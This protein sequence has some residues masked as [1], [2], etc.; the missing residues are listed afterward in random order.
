[1]WQSQEELGSILKNMLTAKF[2]GYLKY[3]PVLAL[4]CGSTLLLAQTTESEEIEAGQETAGPV[5]LENSGDQD[6]APP[7]NDGLGNLVFDE[8]TQSY[9]LI[10]DTEGDDYEEPP[11]DR[12]A[13]AEELKRLFELFRQA[14]ANKDYLEAD[15]L[16]KRVVELSISLN[17]LDSHDTA[18]AITNLG[19]AQHNNKDY[20]SALRNFMA[21]IDIIE[22][23]DDN[24]SPALI[25]PLQGL[26]ASQAIT[27]RPDLAKLSYERAVHVS[28]VNDGPHNTGQVDI[29]E[30][31]AEL[32]ISQGSWEDATSIQEHIYAIQ[33]RKIDPKS[34]EILPALEQRANWQ[35]RLQRYHRERIT[36]RQI[37]SIIENHHGKDSLE[38]ISPLTNLGKSYLFVSPAEFDYQPEVSA[39]SGESYLRR[40]RIIAEEHP[41]STWEIVEDAL[42]SLG[43]YYILA[44]R[45]NRA[46]TVYEDTWAFLSEGDDPALVQ[47][48]R[49]HLEKTKVLQRAFPPKYYNSERNE[50]DQKPD[51]FETGLM[52]FT[53]T[54]SPTGR[55]TNLQLIES[56][57]R[58]L[59]EFSTTIGRSLRRMI[60]RPRMEDARLVESPDT[61]Y[62]HEFYYR[63]A[64]VPKPPPEPLPGENPAEDQQDR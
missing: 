43:D 4:L 32:H 22:R 45:P 36:W 19:I 15:T 2:S 26:A 13:E 24:L 6:Q 56:Q 7:P 25:N 9:R 60:Y 18:K 1:V 34:L 52:S 40:A 35:H 64:D 27:G 55:V 42:L 61:F 23:I 3:S 33:A 47:A 37:I 11:S 20:E 12:E 10:E 63:P 41:D 39:S 57:P 48:R 51:S 62:T 21:S 30:S 46:E 28:H 50:R 16:A 58:E 29:L 31:M 14:L 59:A 54:V 38:L 44:G 5:L 49:D 53:F 8:Q 17:G